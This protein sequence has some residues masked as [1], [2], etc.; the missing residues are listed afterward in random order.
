MST[1]KLPGDLVRA[2]S[3]FQVWRAQR[4]SGSR[5]PQSLWRLAVRLASSHGVS[6]TALALGVD[7]YS[8]KRRSEEG[9]QDGPA[10]GPAFIE[11]PTPAV[12]GK[13][14]LFELGNSAGA[15]MRVQLLGYDATE[16]E[17]MARTLWNAD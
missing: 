9:S 2:R 13:Q 17:T 3:R 10:T 11:L 6:R 7:Y 5:I 4:Q 16:I 15:R 12:V 1:S 14:C 8:L